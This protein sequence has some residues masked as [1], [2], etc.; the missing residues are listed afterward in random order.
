MR[1]SH[2]VPTPKGGG[3]GIFIA[4]LLSAVFVGLSANFWVPITILS[5]VSFWGDRKNLSP[6]TRLI[7]QTSLSAFIV[8]QGGSLPQYPLMYFLTLIWW[9]VFIV[10][11][12]NFYNFMDG[13]NGIAGIT[14]VIGFGLLGAYI[15]LNLFYPKIYLVTFC[16]SLS[17]L[18][19]LSLNLPRAKVFMGDIGSVFLGSVFAGFIFLTTKSFLDFVCMTSFLF[20]FYADELMTMSVRLKDKENLFRPHRKHFYQFLANEMGID[21]WKISVGYGIVQLIIG[22]S[23]LFTRHLGIIIVIFLVMLY[24]SGAIWVNLIVRTRIARLY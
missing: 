4:F 10:G 1:S 3:L 12:A 23:I 18:G 8:I 11:T 22:L 20:P 24:F 13:I 16:I 14:G 15:Y 2:S 6:K 7:T 5:I 21:H 9:V 19:F 17:C